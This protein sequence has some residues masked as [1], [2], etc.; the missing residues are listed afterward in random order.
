MRTRQITVTAAVVALGAATLAGSVAGTATGS[1]AASA[2][3]RFTLEATTTHETVL[4]LGT[5]DD[6]LGSQFVSAHDLY[7]GGKRVGNDGAS[8]QIIDVVSAGAL[9]V[10]C[11]ASLSLPEGQL[12]TQGLTI[13]SEDDSTPL[14]FAVTGGTGRYTGATGKV[15]VRR[16]D[17]QHAR[18][19]V[20]LR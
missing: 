10:Q 11:V 16:L 12:T 4:D 17:D 8:C 14:V 19:T 15:V 5:H 7:R 18:Y 13:G 2:A 9:R 1:S 3:H 6:P 20:T